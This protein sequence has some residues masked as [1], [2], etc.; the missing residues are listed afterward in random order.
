[1]INKEDDLEEGIKGH[2]NSRCEDGESEDTLGVSQSKLQ[3][4]KDM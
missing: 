3:E 1:M 2:A 4:Y